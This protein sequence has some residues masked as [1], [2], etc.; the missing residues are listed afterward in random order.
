M[1]YLE[2]KEEEEEGNM[3]EGDSGLEMILSAMA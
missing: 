2:D 1:L 3:M